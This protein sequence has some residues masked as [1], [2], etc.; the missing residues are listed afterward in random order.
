MC[1]ILGEIQSSKRGEV[2]PLFGRNGPFQTQGIWRDHSKV[3]NYFL[4]A[5]AHYNFANKGIWRLV[6]Q[7]NYFSKL[8]KPQFLGPSWKVEW[9][10][11]LDTPMSGFGGKYDN[12]SSSF[13]SPQ[14]LTSEGGN[15]F[16]GSLAVVWLFHIW[17]TLVLSNSVNITPAVALYISFSNKW[18]LFDVTRN[19]FSQNSFRW[20]TMIICFR[21]VLKMELAVSAEEE[22][23]RH[24]CLSVC[25]SSSHFGADD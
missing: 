20:M 16:D 2:R 24:I 7:P 12:F 3:I 1:T 4:L 15:F 8:V 5:Y 9:W 6:I 18:P 10:G 19:V 21:F 11:F 23:F 17:Q 14:W 25:H 13:Y 22:S